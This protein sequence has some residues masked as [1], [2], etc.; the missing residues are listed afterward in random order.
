[1][2]GR[3]GRCWQMAAPPFNSRA[4]AGLAPVLPWLRGRSDIRVAFHPPGRY[5]SCHI[6][7]TPI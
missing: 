2:Q 1:M 5:C 7:H 4:T 3:P 6:A